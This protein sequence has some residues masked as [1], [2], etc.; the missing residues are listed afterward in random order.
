MNYLFNFPMR[1]KIIQEYQKDFTT[2]EWIMIVV[3]EIVLLAL[4]GLL[5]FFV[6]KLLRKIFRFHVSPKK[7]DEMVKQLKNLQRDLLRANYEKDKLLSMRMAELGVT[8][9]QIE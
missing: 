9:E 4:A 5:V 6:I 1:F 8:Q 3:T 7:Y 2:G